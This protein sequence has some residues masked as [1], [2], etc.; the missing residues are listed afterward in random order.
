MKLLLESDIDLNV[1]ADTEI[2]LRDKIYRLQSQLRNDRTHNVNGAKY[3]W[4]RNAEEEL[5]ELQQELA[6]L[7]GKDKIQRKEYEISIRKDG[8]VF[9][10]YYNKDLIS[11]ADAETILKE[12][13]RKLY[14]QIRED[15]LFNEQN[16]L[17]ID[18]NMK[19]MDK[20]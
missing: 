3:R 9:D 18:V 13:F 19:S 15:F 4:A 5:A 1:A 14:K 11:I 8:K 7:E 17:T 20:E 6:E 2:K 10:T 12:S 16:K